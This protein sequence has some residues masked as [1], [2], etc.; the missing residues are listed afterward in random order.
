MVF[1]ESKL[2]IPDHTPYLMRNRLYDFLENHLSCSL[3][4]LTSDGGY[5]KTTL[6]SSFIK[7]RNVQAVWYQ[8]TYADRDPQTFLSYLKTAIA[9]EISG[10]QMT[11]DIP[12]DNMQEE[13]DKIIAILSTW[14]KQL[15]IVLDNYQSIDQSEKIEQMLSAITRQLSDHVTFLITSR[16]RPNLP[17]SFLKLQNSF[18]ELTTKDI[19]F[20]KEE[21]YQFFLNLHEISLLENEIH[22]VLQKTE[23]WAASLQLLKD[24]IK[25][26]ERK[27][28]PSFWSSF[29]GTEDIYHYLGSEIIAAQPEDIKAFLYKTS[30]LA[31][32]QPKVINE[33]LN[34]NDAE[35]VLEH[36]LK[37]NLFIYK[38]EDGTIKY[39]NLFKSFL[40]EELSK[41][42]SNSDII[43][44][45]A[46]LAAIYEQNSSYFYAFGHAI[47]SNQFLQAAWLMSNMKELYNPPQFLV[48]IDGLLEEISPQMKTASI[49]LFLF[50]CIP[51]TI[52]KKLAVKLEE[53]IE[54]PDESLNPCVKS[55]LQHQLAAICFYSGDVLKAL[56]LCSQ[57]LHLSKEHK[58]DEMMAI[59]L[60]LKALIEWYMDNHEHAKNSAQESLSYPEALEHFHPHHLATWVLA[61]INLD[62]GHLAKA[63]FLLKETLKI[64]KRRHDCSIVYPYGSMGKLYR[65]KNEDQLALEWANEA[66]ALAESFHLEFDLAWIYKET[67]LI[68][69]SSRDWK[70]TEDYLAQAL[71]YAKHA[72]YLKCRI[73]QQQI[74]FL[75]S[76]GKTEDAQPI[77]QALKNMAAKHNYYW[78][79]IPELV[80]LR[81]AEHGEHPDDERLHLSTLGSFQMTYKGRQLHIKRKTSLRLLLYLIT[82]R[83]KKINKEAILDDVFGEGLPQSLNNQFYVALSHLRKTLEPDL[84]KG[85]DSR[86]I[87]RDGEHY[88]LCMKNIQLDADHFNQL[89]PTNENNPISEQVPYLEEAEQLYNGDYLEEFPYEHFLELEREKYRNR[90]LK[91]LHTLA[92]YYWEHSQ[93]KQGMAYYEKIITEDPYQEQ[94]YKEFMKKLLEAQFYVQAKKVSIQYKKYIEKEL[95]IPVHDHIK[96]IFSGYAETN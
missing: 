49:S 20:T 67:A 87:K 36:L 84:K 75:L 82:N 70:E 83:A 92:S 26:M 85:K 42:S 13:L 8:L 31:D 45:H 5:G 10:G 54:K 27:D 65:L 79:S 34:R 25:N 74:T 6:V 66:K 46:K 38:N 71:R 9:R 47:A 62:Q 64:S 43:D 86:F 76:L 91:T 35:V 57:S 53:N 51:L 80:E 37:N 3:I 60:A 48:L 68:Y 2:S 18:A 78:L 59:N 56:R 33:Y 63:E 58:D 44:L 61:E 28:R 69:Q 1:Y 50:R 23:G 24:L 16:V 29:S 72:D 41:H 94:L 89:L 12:A 40:Y 93:Y 39:H 73:Y 52:Q 22:L 11:Y 88:Y 96:E 77:I 30:L 90:Y 7:E 55:V 95:G 32:L 4:C 14:P 15:V 19:A 81:E 17:L 21:I